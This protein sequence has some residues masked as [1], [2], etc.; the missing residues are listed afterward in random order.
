MTAYKH[1]DLQILAG[2]LAKNMCWG[3]FQFHR[4]STGTVT[5][6]GNGI[7]LVKG[8]AHGERAIIVTSLC[9]FKLI[10]IL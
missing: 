5:P 7:M 10:L 4:L 2:P 3:K 1:P 6:L 9:P 8:P